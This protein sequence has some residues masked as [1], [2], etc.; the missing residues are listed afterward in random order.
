MLR[1]GTP[2][3]LRSSL[4]NMNDQLKLNNPLALKLKEKYPVWEKPSENRMRL[5]V[6]VFALLKVSE[7]REP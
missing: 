6:A 1:P 7:R 3:I 5:V 4:E 2:K